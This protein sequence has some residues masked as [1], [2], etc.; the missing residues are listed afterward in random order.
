MFRRKQF[1]KDAQFF[2][3]LRRANAD[4]AV[5]HCIR[6]MASSGI[7]RRMALVRTDVSEEHS[8]SFIGVTR[9]GELRT[10]LAVTRT[11][12]RCELQHA[13]LLVHRFLSL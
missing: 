3:L 8:A 5:F 12:A 6:R 13:L 4:G 10:T 7:L 1:E 9:I 2:L 11:D